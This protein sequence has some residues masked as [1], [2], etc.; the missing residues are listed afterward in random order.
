MACITVSTTGG[1]CVS[2]FLAEFLDECPAA[3]NANLVMALAGNK[4]DLDAKR[5]I[6]QEVRGF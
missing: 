5:S 2:S 1:V 3:G 6:S 4:A